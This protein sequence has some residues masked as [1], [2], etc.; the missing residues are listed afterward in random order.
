MNAKVQIQFPEQLVPFYSANDVIKVYTLASE[1]SIQ[2]RTLLNQIKKSASF[3]KTYAKEHNID[4]SIFNEMEN[5]IAVAITLSD[6]QLNDFN[7]LKN[8]LEETIEQFDSGDLLDVYFYIHEAT[9]WLN[10]LCYQIVNEFSIL[11]K[12]IKNSIHNSV[13][14]TLENLVFA[15]EYIAIRKTDALNIQREKYEIEWE[16]TKNG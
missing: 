10:T 6:I 13:F 7:N 15:T 16:A 8:K 12:S 5:L 1:T 14:S 2:L 3:V 4:D 9:M 11:K